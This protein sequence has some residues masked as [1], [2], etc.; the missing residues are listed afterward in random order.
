MRHT[1]S[2]P[3]R[4]WPRNFRNPGLRLLLA[5]FLAGG[6]PGRGADSTFRF[7][8][9]SETSL[10]LWEDERPV[11]V[12]NHGVI[13]RPGVPADRARSTYVHPLYGL[14]GEE[15]TDDFP[16]DHHHHRGLFWAWP[17]VRVEGRDYDLWML[18]GVRQQFERWLARDTAAGQAVL[19]VENGWYVGERRILREEVW[20]R[21]RPARDDHRVIDVVCAWTPLESA[22]TLAGAEGKSYGGLTLR[23]APNRQTVITTPL[24]QG[25]E[26]LAVTRLPWADLSG[27]FARG[28]AGAAIL[29]APNHPDYPPTWLTRHYGVLC[30]GW[31]GVEPRTFPPGETIRCAYRLWIH[32]GWASPEQVERVY[33][34]YRADGEAHGAWAPAVSAAAMPGP[35]RAELLEDRLVVQARGRLF[36]EYRFGSDTKSPHFFPV[37]GPRSGRS[38]TASGIE[39]YPHHASIFLGCDRVNGGNYWQEGPER[40]RIVSR[41]VRLVRDRGEQVEFEQDCVWERPGAEAPFKDRRRITLRSPDPDVY[42]LDWEVRLTARVPVKIEKTN[43]SLFAV[44]VAPDLAVTRG[45][46]LL[47]AHGARAEAGTF[48]QPAPWAAFGARRE[49]GPE[50]VALFSHPRNPWFPERWFT[51]DYGFMSPTPLNWLPPEGFSLAAGEVLALRYRVVVAAEEVTSPRLAEWFK[52]WSAE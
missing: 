26:D 33:A 20:F 34:D 35:L 46:V 28:P 6:V 22:V 9:T 13:Q 16:A 44:R 15:L 37:L 18:R 42:F 38:V 4:T 45:G 27:H 3:T 41:Q 23:F 29:I 39:P 21:V 17:H 14:D 2:N 51:R 52:A 32:R 30:V 47:N 31:P 40:G 48:G 12:Y 19:G 49:A 36:T 25:G 5:A 10:G 1:G 7:T 11:F 8:P 24:G 50:C 43:H